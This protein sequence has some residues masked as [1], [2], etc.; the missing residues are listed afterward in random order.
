MPRENKTRYALLGMLTYSSMSGYDMK[1][2]SDHSIG[3]FWN[4]NFGNIY[5][6]LKKLRD[7]GLVTMERQEQADAPTRKVYTI[8][9]AGRMEFDSWLRR[10]PEPVKLREESLLQLFFGQWIGAE[11]MIAKLRDEEARYAAVVEELE[12]VRQHMESGE[13]ADPEAPAEMKKIFEEGTPYWMSTV[14]FGLIFYKGKVESCRKTIKEL[15]KTVP[16][17]E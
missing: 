16:G 4:E 10:T 13:G 9:E 5:P 6:V 15:E 14:V 7:A 8:T 3:H 2:M 17:T 11:A 12:G 1:K